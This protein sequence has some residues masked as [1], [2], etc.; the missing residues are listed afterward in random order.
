ML[1]EVTVKGREDLLTVGRIVAGV[2]INDDFGRRCGAG[3]DEPIDQE[4][5]EDLDAS[6]LGGALFE[7]R[8]AVFGFQLGIA[9]GVSVLV[10]V[11]G[12]AT[13]ER[14]VVVGRDVGDG[15]EQGIVAELWASLLSG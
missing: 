9:A 6:G 8:G 11:Q 5:V 12:G 15:L 10:T 14:S 13:G 4:V 3:A 2:E 7:Q 1:V